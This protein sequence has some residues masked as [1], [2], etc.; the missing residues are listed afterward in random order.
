MVEL[1]L[2]RARGHEDVGRGPLHVP[3]S[4]IFGQYNKSPAQDAFRV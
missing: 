3:E 4:G 1:W 2:S